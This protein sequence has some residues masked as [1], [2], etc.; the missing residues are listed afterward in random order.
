MFSRQMFSLLL[1]SETC[2][3]SHGDLAAA[4]SHHDSKGHTLIAPETEAWEWTLHNSHMGF[5]P[6]VAKCIDFFKTL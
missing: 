3:G 5:G 1:L 6:N 2:P 4:P